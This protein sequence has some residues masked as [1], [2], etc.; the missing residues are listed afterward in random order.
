MKKNFNIISTTILIVFLLLYFSVDYFIERTIKLSIRS[1]ELVFAKLAAKSIEQK[2]D[3]YHQE[4]DKI[5][6]LNKDFHDYF[7]L[8]QTFLIRD[9]IPHLQSEILSP[10]IL[11]SKKLISR[12]HLDIYLETKNTIENLSKKLYELKHTVKDSALKFKNEK[13][14]KSAYISLENI[15]QNDSFLI[16]KKNENIIYS[17]VI[18][19]SDL[20]DNNNYNNN[21]AFF[22]RSFN[23]SLIYQNGSLNFRNKAKAISSEIINEEDYLKNFQIQ[24][25]INN[26]LFQIVPITKFK[27]FYIEAK[28]IENL[29]QELFQ[30]KRII[31]FLFIISYLI[32]ELIL[33]IYYLKKRPSV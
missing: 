18:Y 32:L 19:P 4:I 26:I 8:S 25:E 28:K 27:I 21:G 24:R 31:L 17:A 1:N 14:E 23:N 13:S 29:D 11:N 12:E 30:L 16:L 33:A 7:V 22:I 3:K 20:I 15:L 5:Q 10:D 9:G 6:S 2:F